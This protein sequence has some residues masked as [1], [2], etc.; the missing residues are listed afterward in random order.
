MVRGAQEQVVV[1][2]LAGEQVAVTMSYTAVVVRDAGKRQK[3]GMR[4]RE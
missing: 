1:V 2:A 3:I 4:I